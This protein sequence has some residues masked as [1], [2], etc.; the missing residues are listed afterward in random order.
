MFR[1]RRSTARG[2]ACLAGGPLPPEHLARVPSYVLGALPAV[3]V[4]LGGAWVECFAD[5]ATTVSSGGIHT[6]AVTSGGGATCW[7]S[8]SNGRLGD[9]TTTNRTTPT[10][11]TGLTSGVLAVAAGGAHSCALGSGHGV[12]CWGANGA[13]QLGDGTTTER[14]TPADVV[15]LTGGVLAIATGGSHTCALDSG[16][17]VECWG[18]NF[19][20]QLGDGTTA[21]RNAPT[22]VGGL[23]SGVL[24]I[25]SGESH[26][27]ALTD[28]HGVKCWGANDN[29]QLGDGT[30]TSRS[31]PVDVSGLTS[32]VVA[33]TAAPGGFHTCA[34]TSGGGVKCWG[35]GILGHGTAEQRST[36]TDVVGLSSG[37]VA[38]GAG[39]THT[40]ALTSSGAVKC[41]GRELVRTSRGRHEL[42]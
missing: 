28:S 33:V 34:L 25:A 14:L 12:K 5:S 31:S 21:N 30:T 11:V 22:E 20:G 15:G 1:H 8:N 41:S 18:F 3:L 4:A 6:C 37:V 36:P 35:Q 27:C 23:S 9:G 40:C 19:D 38:V 29:G 13:G 7:G 10:D 42:Q 39:G 26:T 24:A 17:G 2:R 32:G 16:G